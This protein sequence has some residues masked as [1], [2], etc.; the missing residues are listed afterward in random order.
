MDKIPE[1]AS[2]TRVYIEPVRGSLSLPHRR[3]ARGVRF[4][5]KH[6]P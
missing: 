6:T 2:I 1:D 4:L 3:R 5:L